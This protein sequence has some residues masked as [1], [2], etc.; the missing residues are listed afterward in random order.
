VVYGDCYYAI[1]LH[2]GSFG[3]GLGL[4]ERNQMAKEID[5][6][7]FFVCIHFTLRG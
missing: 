3:T 6:V 1:I 2:L 4:D 5:E 7:P